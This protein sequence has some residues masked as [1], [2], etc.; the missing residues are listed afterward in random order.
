M[1]LERVFYANG[2]QLNLNGDEAVLV[3]KLRAIEDVVAAEKALSEGSEAP[4]VEE[5]EVARIH[6][7]RS[8]LH[9]IMTQMAQD[10]QALNAAQSA[11]AIS[12]A[13]DSP[14]VPRS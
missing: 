5:K 9:F 7:A 6:I 12:T 13:G 3:F 14:D 2:L 4:P 8:L 10:Y 11:Q 1:D